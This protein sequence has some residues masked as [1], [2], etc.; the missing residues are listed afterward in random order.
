MIA[1]A[2]LKLV[3]LP[4]GAGLIFLIPRRDCLGLIEATSTAND[5]Q[6]RQTQIPRRDCLGLIEAGTPRV[7]LFLLSRFRGVIASAS[8]K[9]GTN[10]T[11]TPI[12]ESMIPRRD[13]LGLIE[14]KELRAASPTPACDSEA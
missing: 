14:A 9:L 3:K 2:S 4:P 13:C 8:L 1:S 5:V 10:F 12:A 11:D 6:P 7:I